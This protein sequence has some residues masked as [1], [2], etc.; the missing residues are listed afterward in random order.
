MKLKYCYCPHLYI[1]WQRV[2][3]NWINWSRLK[4]SLI[5]FDVTLLL[6]YVHVINDLVN[7]SSTLNADIHV[8]LLPIIWLIRKVF[9]YKYKD[10]FLV[11]SFGSY[12][13]KVC[14][15]Y[16]EWMSYSCI[17]LLRFRLTETVV[18]ACLINLDW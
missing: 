15:V 18:C 2:L 1:R 6:V 5:K 17:H 14:L 11:K 12:R 7:F 10:N 13:T 4:P 3:K 9:D 8:H 16:T